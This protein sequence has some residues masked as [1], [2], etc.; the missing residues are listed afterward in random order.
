[1]CSFVCLLFVF[2]EPPYIYHRVQHVIFSF[3]KSH[4]RLK[5]FGKNRTLVISSKEEVGCATGWFIEKS[6]LMCG[7]FCVPAGQ[8]TVGAG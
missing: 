6:N 8:V 2:E 7:L 5:C 3:L 4:L 1:M